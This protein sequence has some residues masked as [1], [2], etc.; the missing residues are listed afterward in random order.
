[1][2]SLTP[3]HQV[4]VHL[5]RPCEEPGSSTGQSNRAEPPSSSSRNSDC[6]GRLSGTAGGVRVRKLNG[7]MVPLPPPQVLPRTVHDQMLRTTR[8]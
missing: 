2:T 3:C 6:R 8:H 4:G 1:M 7:Q 5:M